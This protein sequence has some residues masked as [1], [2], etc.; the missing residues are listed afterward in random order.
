MVGKIVVI[1]LFI[2]FFI[3]MLD[4]IISIKY[5][6]KYPC[7]GIF[8]K[9]GGGKTLLLTAYAKQHIKKKWTVYA[10]FPCYI[11]GVKQFNDIDFKEGK[12]LPDGRNDKGKIVENILLLVDEIGILY[13]NR[14]FKTNFSNPEVLDFWKKHRHRGVKIIYASQSYNDMDKK[15]RVLTDLY[16]LMKDC[17]LRTIKIGKVVQVNTDISND[18]K[19]VGGTIIDL[20]KY[21]SLL[22]WRFLYV[23][24]WADKFNSF[25]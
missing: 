21:S 14:D 16:V 12:W 4:S 3:I 18:N 5:I 25:V 11:N 17:F 20:Y 22:K 24:Y 2:A 19:E 13:N 1:L 8:G 15:L 6:N 9:P 7:I 23:P 10:D